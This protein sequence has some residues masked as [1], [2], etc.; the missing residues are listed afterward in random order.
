MLLE[1]KS[2]IDSGLL[3]RLFFSRRPPT[4]AHYFLTTVPKIDLYQS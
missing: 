1:F 4:V 2:Y 3:L